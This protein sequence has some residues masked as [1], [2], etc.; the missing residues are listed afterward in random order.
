[1]CQAL[2]WRERALYAHDMQVVLVFQ[3]YVKSYLR[4]VSR[5]ATLQILGSAVS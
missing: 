3:T 5:L 4:L 2:A 1:M